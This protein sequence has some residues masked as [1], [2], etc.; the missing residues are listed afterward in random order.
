MITLCPNSFELALK[1]PNFSEWVRK[2][3]LTEGEVV[4]D[5]P[6][7]H[8]YQCPLC[9]IRQEKETRYARQCSFCKYPMKYLGVVE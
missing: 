2:Q 1:K 6:I 5:D 8:A 3:L 9:K 4:I 7:F